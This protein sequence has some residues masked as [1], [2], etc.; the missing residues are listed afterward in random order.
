LA[1]TAAAELTPTSPAGS[2]SA[3]TTFKSSNKIAYLEVLIP[4][5]APFKSFSH[6]IDL[7]NFA[8]ESLSPRILS[9]ALFALVHAD[10][11]YIPLIVLV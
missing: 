10:K 8:S 9:P 4:I 3:Y 1:R 11:T 2:F 7:E 6:P 5:P